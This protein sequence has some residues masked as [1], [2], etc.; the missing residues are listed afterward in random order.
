MNH[1]RNQYPIVIPRGSTLR[2]DEGAGA[3]L[4]VRRGELWLTEEGGGVDHLLQSGQSFWITRDGMTL[5]LALRES[6]VAVAAA[7]PASPAQSIGGL[8]RRAWASLFGSSIQPATPTFRIRENFVQSPMLRA[9]T[10]R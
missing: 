6:V 1:Q 8:L 2:I 9:D 10:M 5:A 4:Y 3:T 7:R